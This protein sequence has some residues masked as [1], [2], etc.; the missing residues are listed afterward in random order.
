LTLYRWKQA[1]SYSQ[2]H[3]FPSAEAENSIQKSAASPKKDGAVCGKK[4]QNK[5]LS[6]A[7]ASSFE[8]A[9][10]VIYGHFLHG[11]IKKQTIALHFA[12]LVLHLQR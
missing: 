8:T 3:L 4:Q 9:A 11:K 7:A 10:Y 1:H 12:P 5:I 2:A 6:Y